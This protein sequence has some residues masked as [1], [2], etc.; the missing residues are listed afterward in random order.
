M[1]DPLSVVASVIAVAG[2][3]ETVCKTL[4]KVKML[5]KA[6][7]GLLS[8][9]NEITGLTIILRTVERHLSSSESEKSA[10]PQD[11]L[12]QISTLVDRANDH[13]LQL[14]HL[15][16]YRFLE[17]GSLDGDY[18]VFRLRWITSKE[19]IENHRGALKEIR[20]DIQL[21]LL[22]LN[23]L[24]VTAHG[25]MSLNIPL[26]ASSAQQSRI[27]LMIEEVFL[28]S[29]QIRSGQLN[30]FD[31]AAQLKRHSEMLNEIL[32]GHGGLRD[33]LRS[34]Q[35]LT[36]QQVKPLNDISQK[37][38]THHYIPSVVGVKTHLSM[39]QR[40]P[41]FTSCT[42][43]CH[44]VKS[45]KSP[46]ILKSILGFL[47]VRYSGYPLDF[48]QPCSDSL[49]QSQPR[50]NVRVV[51]YFPFWL[52]GRMIDVSLMASRVQELSISLTIRGTIFTT[53]DV[54]R[55]I[56]LDDDQDLRHMLGKRGAR[57]ND[58]SVNSGDSALLVSLKNQTLFMS[59]RTNR[60]NL[61]KHWYMK[62]AFIGR[63]PNLTTTILII[64]DYSTWL[65]QI[66]QSIDRCRCRSLYRE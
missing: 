41:C 36:T 31:M 1:A 50:F 56:A 24:V 23:W 26:T 64:D 47:F 13:V 27:R 15:I 35:M 18:K 59:N 16:H 43:N 10:L 30:T 39:F 57:P 29:S 65:L 22:I 46:H 54:Y 34:T 48:S 2:A 53:A 19:T 33:R 8:L 60:T 51:Y 20:E 55:A 17:S 37:G 25:A 58:V 14:H 12:Q 7:N 40:H 42:C 3:T 62:L 38:I 5:R 21:Q 63:E 32:V 66:G 49:C 6:P 44:D 9:H 61:F 28:I 11:I 45:F 4:S 52:F